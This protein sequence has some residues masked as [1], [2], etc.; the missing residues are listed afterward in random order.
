MT[1]SD[2]LLNLS[3][4]LLVLD[5]PVAFILTRAAIRKPH[6][7]A[8]SLFAVASIGIAILIV[9]Y[10]AA[11]TNA[12]LGYPVPRELSQ[13]GFRFAALVL[14]I[15]PPAFLWVYRTGRFRDGDE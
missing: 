14:G 10:I 12:L 15:F 8:L 11:A 6:I 9:S 1:L 3:A 2:V 5:I 13:L 7:W 4:A